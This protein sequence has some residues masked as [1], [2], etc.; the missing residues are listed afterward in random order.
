MIDLVT[1]SVAPLPTHQSIE[2]GTP[3]AEVIAL[4][5]GWIMSAISAWNTIRSHEQDILSYA[6][7]RLSAV[8]N[9]G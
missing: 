6:H 5:A 4:G 3:I 2:A 1:V 7:Q 8:E 9:S